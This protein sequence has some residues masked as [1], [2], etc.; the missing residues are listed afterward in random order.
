MA[1]EKD[2]GADFIYVDATEELA[3]HCKWLI[4]ILYFLVLLARL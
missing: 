3:G 1:I 2:S 4:K